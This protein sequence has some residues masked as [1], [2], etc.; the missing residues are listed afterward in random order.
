MNG[1]A[2]LE[3]CHQQGAKIGRFL[4]ALHLV[5]HRTAMRLACAKFMPGTQREARCHGGEFF[6]A[7]DLRG[8]KPLSEQL[9]HSRHERRPSG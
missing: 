5:A 2:R 3:P 4:F 8:A 6:A 9:S 1:G 7:G